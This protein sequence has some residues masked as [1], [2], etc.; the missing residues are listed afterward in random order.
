MVTLEIRFFSFPRAC[1][2]WLFLFYLCSKL[3]LCQGSAWTVKVRV[4]VLSHFSC[5]WLCDP[6]DCSLPGYSAHG[7]LQARILEWVDISFSRGSSW[8]RD[9]ICI[10]YVSCIGRQVLDHLGLGKPRR[11]KVRSSYILPEPVL[12]PRYVQCLISPVYAIAFQ[13][14][15]LQCLTSKMR[16]REK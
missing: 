10:S 6:M 1:Y 7:I 12:S 2:F 4:Y 13:C 5:V 15:S 16:K 9:Q 3:S 8:L 11:V 14:Y